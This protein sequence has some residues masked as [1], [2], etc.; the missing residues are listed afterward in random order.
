MPNSSLIDNFK[1][2]CLGLFLLVL[3]ILT[4]V[5]AWACTPQMEEYNM[6]AGRW[7]YH[8]YH[9]GRRDKIMKDAMFVGVVRPYFTPN[10]K[11]ETRPK[12]KKTDWYYRAE[13][14]VW[15]EV[16]FEIVE[17]ISGDASIL[18]TRMYPTLT[19][20][21]IAK[22]Y[23]DKGLP[24]IP[25]PHRSLDI[26]YWEVLPMSFPTTGMVGDMDSCGRKRGEYKLKTGVNYVLIAKGRQYGDYALHIAEPNDPLVQS[27]RDVFSGRD[28]HPLKM[29]AQ[30][31]FE[32]MI[33]FTHMTI[34]KCPLDE[35]LYGERPKYRKVK[36][37]TRKLMTV[38]DNFGQDSKIV[39]FRNIWRMENEIRK[40]EARSCDIGQEILAYRRP[41][42]KGYNEF[43]L[44]VNRFLFVKNGMV[45]MDDLVTNIEVTGPKHIA[46]EQIKT[47]IRDA[48]SNE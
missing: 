14:V 42:V 11:I 21:G 39:D 46:V 31:Y 7:S 38:I 47:W 32:N 1:R 27:F 24:A 13:G 25:A 26:G 48:H 37:H 8:S 22:I 18:G 35:Q 43:S 19:P 30:N 3:G 12:I 20:K 33:E 34:K 2:A 44:P 36:K 6:M 16:G 41:N 29:T 40:G 28:A 23:G 9:V 4:S 15:K 5:S 45:S 10:G 17:T